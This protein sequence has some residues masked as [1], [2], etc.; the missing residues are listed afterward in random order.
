M[1]DAKLE[2]E[3]RPEMKEGSFIHEQLGVR[4][5]CRQLVV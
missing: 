4:A 2:G 1:C 5:L 3:V